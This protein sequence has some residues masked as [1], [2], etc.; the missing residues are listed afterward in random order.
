VTTVVT[1]LVL[2]APPIIEQIRDRPGNMTIVLEYF[3]NA[4]KPIGMQ[5]AWW[6]FLQHLDVVHVTA[7]S[8][9]MPN[10]LSIFLH[11][12]PAIAWRGGVCLVLWVVAVVVALR[13]RHRSLLALHAV[14]A[15]ALV[16][17]LFALS[18]IIGWPFHYLTHSV[19][20][21]GATMWLA[22]LSTA[23]VAIWPRVPERARVRAAPLATA[24]AIVAVGACTVD[25]LTQ[26]TSAGS[27]G[28]RVTT[29]QLAALAPL[30]ANALLERDARS[31]GP[32]ARYVA[33]FSETLRLAG[34]GWGLVNELERRGLDVGV[35]APFATIFTPHRVRDPKT[36][37]ARVHLATG[38]WIDQ[39]RKIPGAVEIAYVDG[40]T[41]EA[42][43]EYE[44]LRAN[45][46]DAL[47]ELGRE[48]AVDELDRRLDGSMVPGM[49]AA[50]ALYLKRM[51]EIGVP[52]AVFLIP[53]RPS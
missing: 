19:W 35:G 51:S 5:A 42:R 49:K 21:V 27:L 7:T 47:R 45:V 48:D 12:Q 10:N 17:N 33:T 39:A 6:L 31:P 44:R 22:T 28:A 24:V 3:R 32:K 23:A 2:W 8:F 50:N 46:V 13:L 20:I 14:I 38:G 37:T 18:R 36:A 52:A 43:E 40:R 15:V 34:E 9:L 1:V 29:E 25:L 53:M 41:P 11:P 26:V 30:A 16:V 4:E